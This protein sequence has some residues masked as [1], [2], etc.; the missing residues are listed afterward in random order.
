VSDAA[1]ADQYAAAGPGWVHFL[2]GNLLYI[3]L[4]IGAIALVAT[5]GNNPQRAAAYW[6]Y[7]I[8]FVGLV[9]VIG[10]WR[11]V[12]PTTRD[13]VVYF[14]RQILHWGALLVAINLLF[15]PSMQSFLNA[16]SHG[17]M[18]AYLLGLAAILSGIYLDW[19]MSV[20]G[21]FLLGSAVGVG[22]LDDN[23]VLLTIS[24]VAVAAVAVTFLVG[25]FSKT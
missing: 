11:V 3:L 23:A 19:K 16:E 22:F 13:K 6:Q 2:F 10:G 5:T 15:L 1:T 12:G 14:I 25:R 9:S 20:F 18:A 21:A 8:L 7:F 4:Y 17:F 24:A